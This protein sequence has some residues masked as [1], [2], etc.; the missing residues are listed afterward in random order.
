MIEKFN[1]KQQLAKGNLDEL[2]NFI[3]ELAHENFE[4]NGRL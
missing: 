2:N 4:E 3:E 1:I